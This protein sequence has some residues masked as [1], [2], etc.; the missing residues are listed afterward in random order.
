VGTAIKP[1]IPRVFSELQEN[2]VKR[3][4]D[5][6]NLICEQRSWDQLR[7]QMFFNLYNRNRRAR[8]VNRGLDEI[9][10]VAL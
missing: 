6:M 8:K 1:K 4:V 2:A 3:L 9:L 7:A 10:A 5:K